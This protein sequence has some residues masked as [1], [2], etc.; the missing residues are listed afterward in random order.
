MSILDRISQPTSKPVVATILGEPGVGKTSLAAAFPKP[1][2]VKIEDGTEGIPESLKGNIAELPEIKSV[3]QL[4]NDL[5]ELIKEE[6]GFKTVVLDSVTALERLFQQYIID[7]DP[8]KPKSI[9]TAMGGYGAGFQAVGALHQ[10]V[11]RAAGLLQDKG[12]HVLFLAHVEIDTLDLPDQDPYSRYSLRLNKRS[13][14]PYVDDV[15]AVALVRLE[16]FTKGDDD[17][18]KKAVGNGNR[19]ITMHATPASVTKNRYGIEQDI[20]FPVGSNPLA[21]FIPS[22]QEAK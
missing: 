5:N 11:R 13:M 18:R 19:I 2:F 16:T 20:D 10:R 12:I 15:S 9:N 21:P 1:V 6:H 22:L 3:D 4:W 8:K 17:K 14:A 7:T